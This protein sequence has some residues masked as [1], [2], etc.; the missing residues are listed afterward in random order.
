MVPAWPGL[1]ALLFPAATGTLPLPTDWCIVPEWDGYF[2]EGRVT[3]LE[4]CPTLEAGFPYLPMP[5]HSHR[6]VGIHPKV[7]CPSYT[8][9]EPGTQ[10][11]G[12]YRPEGE[13]ADGKA[14]SEYD[15]YDYPEGEDYLGENIVPLAT[16]PKMSDRSCNPEE[17]S[18]VKLIPGFQGEAKCVALNSCPDLLDSEAAP[19]S[20]VV[21]C[22]FDETMNVLMVCCPVGMVTTTPVVTP[23]P[24]RYPDPEKGG[25]RPC[26]DRTPLCQSRWKGAGGCDLDQNVILSD[27]DK[28][29]SEVSSRD[30]FNFMQTTCLAS[31]GWCGA[32]GCVD[33]HPRCVGWARRGMCVISPFFMAHTCRES[34]GV[35]GFLAPSNT[36]E[37]MVGGRSYTD[38]TR[39]DFDCG[40]YKSLCDIAGGKCTSREKKEQTR[41]K[42]EIDGFWPE[43]PLVD[44]E[45]PDQFYCG[46]TTIS[47]RWVVAAAHCYQDTL[48]DDGP[49]K[50]RVNTV[51]DGTDFRETVEIKRVFKHPLY[52][53]P[54][55]YN[56][57]A[58][59]ELGRRLEYDH[60]RFGDSPSCLD[61]NT[62]LEGRVGTVQGYGET[63]DGTRGNLLETN[64]TL[65]SIERCKEI[66]K[67]N[68]TVHQDD[69]SEALPFGLSH[70]LMCTQG[71]YNKEKDIFSGACRGDDGGPLTVNNDQK[72]TLVGI[73]SGGLGCGNG[74][75][76]WYTRVAFYRDWINCVVERSR[77]AKSAIEVES[78]CQEAVRPLPLCRELREQDLLFGDD[79][80]VGTCTEEEEKIMKHQF[81]I[82]Q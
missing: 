3:Y 17:I 21:A 62:N 74:V 63:E 79:Q 14:Y 19:Q 64:V 11:C 32:K 76:N 65:I 24:P 2:G 31:C 58:L 35:C 68:I 80:A 12:G 28:W 70:G 5:A 77:E 55:L 7:C 45:N 39:D 41:T 81:V 66:L 60:D 50:V 29:N 75:P 27:L 38:F 16:R 37:Q 44:P 67:H 40:R 78:A 47:D 4:D 6:S 13:T 10:F 46:A 61:H 72:T 36:E 25:A 22:G 42:R 48:A 33:E 43:Y 18:E 71:I 20:S 9:C 30:L 69:L 56:N 82:E 53:F 1:L 49:M 51:R 54:R 26:D 8:R 15:D 23:Q 52:T 57:I 59:L 34:C 73:V